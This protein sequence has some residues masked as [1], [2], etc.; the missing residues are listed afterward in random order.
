MS[1][2]IEDSDYIKGFDKGMDKGT[3][4]AKD[5]VIDL[6]DAF[7]AEIMESPPTPKD[8]R[9]FYYYRGQVSILA[10]LKEAIQKK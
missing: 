7:S 2:N 9:A 5:L 1:Q 10:K 3:K 4:L 8:V 6:L